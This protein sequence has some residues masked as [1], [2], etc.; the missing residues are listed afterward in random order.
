MDSFGRPNFT[1]RRLSRSSI[2]CPSRWK[3]RR[4]ALKQSVSDESEIIARDPLEE[5]FVEDVYPPDAPDAAKIVT[6]SIIGAAQ[7]LL[8]LAIASITQIGGFTVHL[9]K[10]DILCAEIGLLGALGETMHNYNQNHNHCDNDVLIDS[11]RHAV[12]FQLRRAFS[13]EIIPPLG[14]VLRLFCSERRLALEWHF[15]CRSTSQ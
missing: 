2:N 14:W 13:K 5:L 8:W 11:I 15:S 3:Q 9:S 12:V 1:A 4:S 7:V 10:V 6:Y